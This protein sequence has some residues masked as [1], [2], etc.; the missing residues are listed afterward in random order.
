ML[1]IRKASERGHA[2]HGWLNSWHTFS[3]ADYYDPKHMGFRSLRVIN[4]DRVQPGMGFNTHPHRDM[5]IISYVLEGA[6]E[7]RDSMGNTSVIRPGEVQRMSAGTGI[8]HSE[9]NHSKS[10]LVHFLQIWILPST[11]GLTPGYEQKFF[12]DEEKKGVLRLIASSDGRNGSVTMHQDANLY[13]ALVEGGE[14]IAYTIPAGRHVWLHVAQGSVVVNGYKLSAGDGLAATE[15]Q[16]LLIAGDTKA[17][18]LLFD[19]A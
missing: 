3:F 17:E 16:Q 10:E 15:E 14:E 11:N 2:D 9:F 6:L 13:S 7:H 18:V 19:L 4:D 1:Q 12:A 5:E 8:T